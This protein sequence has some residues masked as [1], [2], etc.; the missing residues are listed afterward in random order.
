MTTMWDKSESLH[1]AVHRLG[2]DAA[3]S[4]HSAAYEPLTPR[5]LCV[6]RED[7]IPVWDTVC[8]SDYIRSSEQKSMKISNK[9]F[10]LFSKS[11]SIKCNKYNR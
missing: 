5:L 9:N 7:D 11:K 3:R 8:L 4:L 10:I 6:L 2:E 1:E